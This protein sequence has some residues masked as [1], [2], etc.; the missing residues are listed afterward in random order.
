LHASTDLTKVS[1]NPFVRNLLLVLILL[2]SNSRDGELGLTSARQN[3]NAG[4]K[5]SEGALALLLRRGK[6]SEI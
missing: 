2:T 1:L 5:G 6:E 3:A 4:R